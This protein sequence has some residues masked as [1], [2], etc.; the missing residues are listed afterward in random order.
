MKLFIFELNSFH[1]ETLPMYQ[2]LMPALFDDRPIEMHYFVLPHLVE[3]VK[4]GVGEW[5]HPLNSAALRYALPSKTLRGLYYRYRIQTLIDRFA[6]DAIVFNTIEPR[7]YLDVFRRLRHA[8]KI[9]VVHNPRKDDISYQTGRS[10]EVV[11]CLHDYNYRA[12][13][14]DKPVDGYLS[15]FFKRDDATPSGCVSQQPEVVVQ[16]VI[17]FNRRDYAM[18][19]DLCDALAKRAD[20][21]DLVFNILG[22]TTVRDGSQLRHL[23][24][25]RGL[26]R[27]FR[28]H[29]WLSDREFSVNSQKAHFVMPLVDRKNGSYAG[30]AKATA[31]FGQSGA[32]GTPLLL[33]EKTALLWGL[34]ADAC[35]T[36]VDIQDLER[37]LLRGVS[38]REGRA[39]RYRSWIDGKIRENRESLRS[40][41]RSHPALT[42]LR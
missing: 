29:P 42:S 35:V 31:A 15:P 22:D 37:T 28:M 30:R 1:M 33:E 41:A 14:A 11:F 32:Y 16:G 21:P 9:G 25:S 27:F 20:P 8:V 24:A 4:T 40:L 26:E 3:R 5:V 23:V 34:P 2:S 19:I 18:L 17:S 36:Y 12:L 13:L 10:D 7:A 6:P 39:R 38:D